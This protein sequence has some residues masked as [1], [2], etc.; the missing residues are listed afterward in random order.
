MLILN[1]QERECIAYIQQAILYQ[2]P[3]SLEVEIT[4][5]VNSEFQQYIM[6]DNVFPDDKTD[7]KTDDYTDDNFDDKTDDNFRRMN[8]TN[9]FVGSNDYSQQGIEQNIEEVVNKRLEELRKEREIIEIKSKL[10]ESAETITYQK[11]TIESFKQTIE[12]KNKT[13]EGRNKI[14]EEKDTLVKS[15]S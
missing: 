12:D 9:D 15:L 13:I 2:Q 3:D 4:S 8:E 1:Q 11:Q 14:I 5:D 7:D 6:N 10:L